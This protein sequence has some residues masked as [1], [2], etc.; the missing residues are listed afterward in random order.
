MTWAYEA[1][2]GV[3]WWI[4]RFTV[5][6]RLQEAADKLCTETLILT[7]DIYVVFV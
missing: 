5:C 4:Y 6:R 2:W 1:I 3:P 7:D